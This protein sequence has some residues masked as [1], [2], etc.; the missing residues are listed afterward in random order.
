MSSA[1]S[2]TCR[3]HRRLPPAAKDI[4]AAKHP[5]LGHQI[6]GRWIDEREQFRVGDRHG[7]A[8]PLQQRAIVAEIG[9]GGDMRARAAGLLSLRR[10][11]GLT[12]LMQ[13]TAAERGAEEEPVRRQRPPDLD[14][15]AG[16]VV[17][18]MQRQPRDDEI[19]GCVSERQQ[20]LVASDRRAR[21]EALR[22]SARS[23]HRSSRRP[24]AA[25]PRAHPSRRDRRQ[26]RAPAGNRAGSPRSARRSPSRPAP[27]GIRAQ[28][29]R[30]A[31]RSRRCRKRRR[32][33]S[34]RSSLM[35]ATLSRL[36][37]RGASA[38]SLPTMTPAGG[39]GARR[40]CHAAWAWT[41]GLKRFGRARRARRPA[42]AAG[43]HF[44]PPAG[45]KPRPAVRRLLGHDRVH[46]PSDLRPAR[47]A[48]SL[49]NDGALPLGGGHRQSAALRPR[50]RG[51]ALFRHHAR[52]DPQLQIWGP[53]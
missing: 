34:S 37:R 3:G 41:R 46:R 16:Q 4:A 40:R 7:E 52:P 15:R 45:R 26:G 18:P 13:G 29:P 38:V 11:Q 31:K 32:S 23:R 22:A 49:R 39:E 43:L 48:A 20:I 42:A 30:A 44:L 47:R 51:G 5:D 25:P 28:P 36:F 17:D 19:E 33:N 21:A 27:A 10:E 12:Q 6:A 1:R 2:S 35:L 50:P 24:A 8:C 14:Q 53:A 9:E